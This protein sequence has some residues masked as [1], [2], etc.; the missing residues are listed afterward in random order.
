MPRISVYVTD[1]F[2]ARMDEA[3]EAFNW[4]ALAQRAF[5]DALLTFAVRFAKRI[6]AVIGPGPNTH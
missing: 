3:G 4:S 6:R 5:Q 1:D 2:K